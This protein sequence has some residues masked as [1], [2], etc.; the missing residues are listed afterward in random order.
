MNHFF[1]ENFRIKTFSQNLITLQTKLQKNS[2]KIDDKP[3]TFPPPKNQTHWNIW[4]A[5]RRC[6]CITWTAGQWH[7]RPTSVVLNFVCWKSFERHELKVVCTRRIDAGTV[8]RRSRNGR[9][10]TR[11]QTRSE[12]R[13][14]V[15]NYLSMS[16]VDGVWLTLSDELLV[17]SSQ[18]GGLFASRRMLPSPSGFSRWVMARIFPNENFWTLTNL[19]VVL[20]T[21]KNCSESKENK[22]VRLSHQNR[23]FSWNLSI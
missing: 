20:M 5:R 14:K 10:G 2:Y 1:M 4:A 15:N 11:W 21:K 16:T 18:T 6:T 13:K 23:N 12:A 22:N 8:Q 17:I 9:L 19:K 3:K 7:D